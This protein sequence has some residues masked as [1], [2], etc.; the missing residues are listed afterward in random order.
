MIATLL[1]AASVAAVPS[2]SKLG[3]RVVG[4]DAT[5]RALLAASPCPQVAVFP[6]PSNGFAGAQI[7]DYL[8]NC[9]RGIAI[10]RV[11]TDADTAADGLQLLET[12]LSLVPAEAGWVEA[13]AA[14]GT[15]DQVTA[16]RTAFANAVQ[17]RSKIP[18]LPATSTSCPAVTGTF[19][20]SW[21]ARSPMTQ[22]TDELA[23]T[24]GYRTVLAGCPGLSA[25]PLVLT[26][27]AP[28]GRAWQA[29]DDAWLRWFDARL[30]EDADA[31]GAAL[32]SAGD[33]TLNAVADA[34]LAQLAN[35][36]FP[37]GGTDGGADGGT[38]AGGGGVV[39]PHPGTDGELVPVKTKGCSSGASG[40]AIL[41]VL[42]I[43]FAL[44][45][46]RRERRTQR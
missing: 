8:T 36:A 35:P 27:I 38:D 7:R 15:A 18:V 45:W 44:R 1:L 3:V 32:A 19:W 37:D 10:A 14:P 20:W 30:A 31:Q 41:G 25:V 23:T 12:W 17:A 39:T 21:R 40:G 43:L 6:V 2:T 24:L 29:S 13:P 16:F 4:D 46:W 33:G 9:P 5:A 11:G 28:A 34:L 26:D 22:G 42:P